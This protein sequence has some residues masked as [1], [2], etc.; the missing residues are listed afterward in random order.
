MARN[1]RFQH[2][3]LFKRGTRNKVWVVR[4]WEDQLGPDGKLQRIRRSEI[5]G[6]VA[7]YS[8]TPS[9]GADL[10]RIGSAVSIAVITSFSQAA[11]YRHFVQRNWLPEQCCPRLST[12]PRNTTS[13]WL[14]F[15]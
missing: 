6:K 15:I 4:W 1:R 14:M 7:G 8:D 11:R 2:G 13:M 10:F 5:L 3:S 12:Q 9:G